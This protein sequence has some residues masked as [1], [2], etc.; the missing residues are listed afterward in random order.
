VFMVLR[1]TSLTGMALPVLIGVFSGLLLLTGPRGG[2]PLWHRLLLGL[3]GSLVV[4][5]AQHPH[6]IAAKIAT[7]LNIDATIAHL[8]H[9]QLFE[10]QSDDFAKDVT[11]WAVY[12]DLEEAEM[13]A[14]LRFIT[15]QEKDH[16]KSL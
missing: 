3:R 9:Q 10:T 1:L 13:T 7:A 2:L 11:E 14:G 8:H 12:A 15:K 4:A 5:A 6:S 16:G